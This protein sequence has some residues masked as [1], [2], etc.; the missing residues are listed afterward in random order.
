MLALL[1]K[2]N[3]GIDTS[4]LADLFTVFFGPL[5]VP[6]VQLAKEVHG[7]KLPSHTVVGIFCGLFGR[8]SPCHFL[9]SIQSNYLGW[10]DEL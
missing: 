1:Y 5:N 2:V 8:Q 3:D 4:H 10:L 9:D 7:R 6:L